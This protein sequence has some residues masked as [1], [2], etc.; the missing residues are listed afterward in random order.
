MR[1]IVIGLSLSFC[2]VACSGS[3]STSGGPGTPGVEEEPGP[4]PGPSTNGDRL[5]P[6]FGT[7]GEVNLRLDGNDYPTTLLVAR[8]GAIT[9]VGVTAAKQPEIHSGPR[10]LFVARLTKNGGRDA[11]FG[12]DGV[13]LFDDPVNTMPLGAL[14]AD[15]AAIVS[16]KGI[17]RVKND[18][19]L[20][21]TFANGAFPTSGIHALAIAA[22]GKILAHTDGGMLRLLPSGA[23]D[24]TFGVDGVAPNDLS[25]ARK[26]LPLA[27][28]G[29]TLFSGSET[30]LSRY[31]ATGKL[32]LSF[33][34]AGKVVRGDREEPTGAVAAGDGYATTSGN[35]SSASQFVRPTA[36]R[37]DSAGKAASSFGGAGEV[38]G[39]SAGYYG[40]PLPLSDG[41]MLLRLT[42]AFTSS[43]IRVGT[44]GAQDSSFAAGGALTIGRGTPSAEGRRY[45]AMATAL[46]PDEQSVVVLGHSQDPT[47]AAN[48]EGY[49]HLGVW[50]ARYR[51]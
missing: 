17:R 35:A 31:D 22:D 37:F 3:G 20:D 24:A 14:A 11:S 1:T 5:D 8:D 9:I 28:G 7:N 33:G 21:P 46:S 2:V 18:G 47:S 44:D 32:D 42:G 25:S 19:T 16:T 23:V 40:D 49:P 6:T 34:T 39:T 4:G 43:V 26:I 41:R 12:K 45:T 27:S 10:R 50:V 38:V 36:R 15:G 51:L 13:A 30:L 48:D 29:F